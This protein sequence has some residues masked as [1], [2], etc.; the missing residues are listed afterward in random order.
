VISSTR[1]GI[2]T[3]PRVS[4]LHFCTSVF[5]SAASL[6]AMCVATFPEG[7]VQANALLW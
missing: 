7:V 1:L 3:G 4:D 6:S 2:P 5:F